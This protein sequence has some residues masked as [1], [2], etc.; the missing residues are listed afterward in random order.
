MGRTSVIVLILIGVYPP[1][2]IGLNIL[3]FLS[4]SPSCC[5][6]FF[7]SSVVEDLLWQVF[8]FS[9]NTFSVN[10]Y[11]FGEPMRGGELWVFLSRHLES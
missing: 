2:D 10:S 9:V 11:G 4:F 6:S 7:I 1:D 8:I 3:R 5:G